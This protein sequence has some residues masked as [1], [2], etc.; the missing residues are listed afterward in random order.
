M[1]RFDATLTDADIAAIATA[2]E[3]N[4]A[5]GKQLRSKK[6]RLSN[7]DAPATAFVVNEP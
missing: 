5:A 2:L 4:A 6:S 7:A 3:E 1:R